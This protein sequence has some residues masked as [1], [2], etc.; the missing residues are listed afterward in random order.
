M[1]ETSPQ[2]EDVPCP[3]PLPIVGFYFQTRYRSTPSAA[4]AQLP[5]AI[6]REDACCSPLN[7]FKIPQHSK[8][9]KLH[10]PPQYACRLQRRRKRRRRS[11]RRGRRRRRSKTEMRSSR[12]RLL[13]GKISDRG[14]EG[15][16][17]VVVG[18]AE[19]DMVTSEK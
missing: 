6:Y 10:F 11:G 8:S 19:A 16:A 14:G 9:A 3:K 1:H 12:I 2:V 18:K 13:K 15:R 17:A 4:V 5:A 7:F